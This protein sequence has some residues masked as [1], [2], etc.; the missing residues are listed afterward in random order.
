[1]LP[2]P[3]GVLWWYICRVACKGPK[4]GSVRKTKTGTVPR[5]A[6]RRSPLAQQLPDLWWR[7]Q[8]PKASEPWKARLK[9]GGMHVVCPPT[10]TATRRHCG[11]VCREELGGLIGRL[12]SFYAALV[13]VTPKCSRTSASDTQ[14][15]LWRANDLI[16]ETL[17]SLLAY[18][19]CRRR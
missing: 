15:S 10:F 7:R 14:P 16:S 9:W 11:G 1:M 6:I 4:A 18:F 19:T 2:V 5:R 8:Q 13:S 3:R 12:F 17:G